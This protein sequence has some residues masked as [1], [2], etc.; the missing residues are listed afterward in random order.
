[1]QFDKYVA[2]EGMTRNVRSIGAAFMTLLDYKYFLTPEEGR[3]VA[4]NNKK[5]EEKYCRRRR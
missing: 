1:M 3:L 5:E 2:Y 4:I